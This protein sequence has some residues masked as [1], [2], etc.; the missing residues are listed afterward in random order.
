MAHL[1][2]AST[3]LLEHPDRHREPV[4]R[5]QTPSISNQQFPIKRKR[6]LG[7]PLDTFH[8]SSFLH[9]LSFKDTLLLILVPSAADLL[10]G[11]DAYLNPSAPKPLIKFDLYDFILA[12]L[13]IVWHQAKQDATTD[14]TDVLN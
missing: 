2:T 13:P 8:S 10:F 12:L 4:P 11:D 6:K 7:S 5:F 14:S 1:G 9:S 3:V